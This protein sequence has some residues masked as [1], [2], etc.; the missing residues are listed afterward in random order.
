ML[1][2]GIRICPLGISIQEFLIRSI[3]IDLDGARTDLL[4]PAILNR[5]KTRPIEYDPSAVLAWTI[6]SLWHVP[7]A[8]ILY[9][10][11]K[12]SRRSRDHR[13]LL[14]DPD[15]LFY[16]LTA[17]KISFDLTS[18]LC[19]V[20]RLELLTMAIDHQHL[21]REDDFDCRTFNF[22]RTI[23]N[24]LSPDDGRRL[25]GLYPVDHYFLDLPE[26]IY[27]RDRAVRRKINDLRSVLSCGM[28]HFSFY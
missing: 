12:R 7:L 11:T 15:L 2:G 9:D 28:R 22:K 24:R 23:W 17:V 3:I 6:L 13:R 27:R 10:D 18:D 26:T 20:V 21:A 14:A 1:H 5:S 25:H 4:D 19:F 16:Y 8:A